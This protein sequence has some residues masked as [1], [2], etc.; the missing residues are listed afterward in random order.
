MKKV[1]SVFF[2]AIFVVYLTVP[3]SYALY[4]EGTNVAGV[5]KALEEAEELKSELGFSDINFDKLTFSD[6]ILAYEYTKKGFVFNSEFIPIK[7]NNRLVGWV[8]KADY[9]GSAIYQ[10]SN[11]FIGVIDNYI[12][13]DTEFAIIYDYEH[14]YV[15]DGSE[16]YIIGNVSLNVASRLSIENCSNVDFSPIELGN[17]EKTYTVNYSANNDSRASA[18]ISCRVSFVSQEPPSSICW[19]A[20][21]ACIINILLGYNLPAETIARYWY[22]TNFN[23]PLNSSYFD[24]VLNSYNLNYSYRAQVPSD[25][26]IYSNI[27]QGYP[28]MAAFNS[29]GGG[30]AV[31][32]YGINITGGYIA[33]MDPE[34]GFTRAN[35][36]LANGYTYVSDYSGVTLSFSRAACASWSA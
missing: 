36:S 6:S 3:C 29:S 35:Y 8:I 16:I 30:H 25:A 27:N 12:D 10:F 32:V 28:I 11:A 31:V 15:Y 21:A 22:G 2:A 17:Y 4:R 19:A 20:S 26:V 33:V 18:Y 9:N 7:D 13:N 1:V 34:Y 24:D 23:R 5:T 14:C